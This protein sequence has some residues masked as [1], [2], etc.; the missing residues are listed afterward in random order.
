MKALKRIIISLICL[1][2]IAGVAVVGG[3]IFV[4][5]KY[6]IDLIRTV[7]QLKTLTQT[8]DETTLCPNAFNETDFKELKTYFSGDDFTGLIKYD[9]SK[10]YNGY[11]SDFSGVGGNVL[12][13]I[14]LTEKRT[15][16]LSQIM[17]YEQTGGKIKV[18]EKNLTTTIVQV[19]FSNVESGSADFNIVVKIDLTPL[20]ED[21]S[22]F[23]YDIL[24]KYIPNDLYV[25]STTRINKTDEF[26]AYSVSPKQLT[27]N[28]LSADDTVDLFHTLDVL[29]KLGSS[30]SL[31]STIGNTVTN[32][33]IG[34]AE[35]EGFAYSLKAVGKTTCGFNELGENDCFVIS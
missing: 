4:R 17:F 7:G 5:S 23:P 31:N 14:T 13:D 16:A 32:A 2:V 34:N 27:I 30:E 22:E 6:D 28:N 26:M 15:G 12:N 35:K 20:K 11:Y 18:G 21:M 29:L 24:K 10:G 25:S 1:I 9:E 3:Y 19:D 8:V 33:L